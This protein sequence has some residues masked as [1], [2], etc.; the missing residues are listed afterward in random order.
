MAISSIGSASTATFQAN[1]QQVAGKRDSDGDNDGVK[2]SDKDSRKET[3]Q[4][5]A[6]N[7]PIAPAAPSATATVGS[8]IN[9]TA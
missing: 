4:A 3:A 6:A 1:L 2:A 8:I 9:T 5:A 7:T